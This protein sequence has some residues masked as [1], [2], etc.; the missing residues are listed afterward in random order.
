MN[1]N[2][3]LLKLGL[4]LVLLSLGASSAS[5]D[6]LTFDLTAPNLGGLDCCTGPYASVT[7]DRA[8]NTAATVTFN[9][10]TNGGYIYLMG[11][12]Q[13][14]DLNVNAASFTADTISGSTSL[15]GFLPWSVKGTPG[16]QNV[17]GFGIFNLSIDA[18]DGFGHSATQ[19]VVNLTNTSG[20]WA[21]A[22]DV[23]AANANGS[24]AAVHGFACAM[25]GCNGKSGAYTTGYAS[26]G[27]EIEVP[28][29]ATLSLMSGLGVLA[30]AFR[31]RL[32][33]AAD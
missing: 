32:A 13:S 1:A 31:R 6:T 5:A 15:S 22:A 18:F 26:N 19:V 24:T 2:R 3:N 8:S 21:S 17:D 33:R 27:T 28:E 11:G 7:V 20:T 23:L 30:I 14:T 16:S 9:S 25:P 29:P 4:A 10:L 12:A